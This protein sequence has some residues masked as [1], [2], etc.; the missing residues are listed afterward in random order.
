[1]AS[2][3]TSG[4]N[5]NLTQEALRRIAEA[6]PEGIWV[7]DPQGRTI[8]SNHR[9]AEILGV[10]FDSMP[11]QSCFACVFP[12]DAAAAQEH[13]ART[14]GG[15]PQAFD[16]RLRRAD[17]SPTWVS[18]SCRTLPGV[19]G[20]PVALLGLFSDI[21]KRKR[22]EEASRNREAAFRELVDSAPVIT[23]MSTPEI[24]LTYVNERALAFAGVP[25][26][27][28]VGN[29]YQQF[30][31]PEDL[32]RYQESALRAAA[33][34][35]P[36]S[37][38]VRCRR[39]DGEYRWLLVTGVPRFI[40]EGYVGHVGTCVDVTDLKWNYEQHLSTQKLES[41]GVLAAGVA[42]DFN[43]LMSVIVARA[44]LLQSEL[45][46]SSPLAEELHHIRQTALRAIEIGSQLMT[47]AHLETPPSE[48]VNLSRLVEDMADL[49]KVSISK[50]AVLKKELATDLP[51]IC[52]N[53]AEM[54][55]LVMNLIINASEA[56]I[57]KP[58][59]ITIRTAHEPGSMAGARVRLEVM[60]TGCG[61]T[62]EVRTKIFEPFFTTKF[63]GRGLGLS[64]AMG[65]VQRQGGS[66]E[67]ESTPGHGSR[68]VVLLPSNSGPEFSE[69]SGV[70]IA[71]PAG[72]E[73]T[74]LFIEDE[75][76]LRPVVAKLLRKRN[77]QVIES[78]D[79]AGAIDV[80]R[81]NAGAIDVVLLDVSLPGRPGREVFQE[82]QRIRPDVKV[83]L[84]T[85]YSRET[86][87]ADFGEF[88]AWGFVRKPYQIDEL[89]TLL[90]EAHHT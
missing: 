51:S 69:S 32:E 17:G 23:W 28:I 77:F 30:I 79:G 9:M 90:R 10:A 75:E 6:V 46:V 43:N 16:F 68:F 82:L 41:L 40:D 19:A 76:A 36:F 12:E 33:T 65:I 45:G 21:S 56:L 25:A 15:D 64:A 55:Q 70:A 26:E 52:A 1:M 87:T 86:V 66:I 14:L 67:V 8:F 42:H 59:A 4:P 80:F 58:G 54:R 88:R 53:A 20:T 3:S 48:P 38:E 22:A 5:T 50:D 57:G 44:E 35:A 27:Q 29:R 60:D 39:A 47:I 74:V 78:A 73:P 13:F 84:S 85:A 18:I 24:E 62:E 11:E 34:G 2:S 37:M 83:I 49:L 81:A 61:M 71:D 7:V 63:M 89:V 31:H 72:P